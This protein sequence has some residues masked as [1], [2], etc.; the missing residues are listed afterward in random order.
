MKARYIL[1]VLISLAIFFIW[2]CEKDLQIFEEA[3]NDIQMN[4]RNNESAILSNSVLPW[5]H[6]IVSAPDKQGT[7][8]LIA[9]GVDG[10]AHMVYW[11][12]TKSEKINGRWYVTG[13]DLF[14]RNTSGGTLSSPV[15]ITQL[16]TSSWGGPGI[17]VDQ[18]GQVHI[19]YQVKT[20]TECG[21][22]YTKGL[23]DDLESGNF[24]IEGPFWNSAIMGDCLWPGNSWGDIDQA[25]RLHLI[26]VIDQEFYYITNSHG[27]FE[28]FEI[29]KSDFTNF[30]TI[31]IEEQDGI[32]HFAFSASKNSDHNYD[33]YYEKL[34]PDGSFSD[35]EFVTNMGG[36]DTFP[37]IEIDQDQSVHIGHYTYNPEGTYYSNNKSGSFV[38][39]LV[40]GAGFFGSDF[41]IQP[42]KSIGVAL[43]DISSRI[44]IYVNNSNITWDQEVVYFPEDNESISLAG[45]IANNSDGFVHIVTDHSRTVGKYPRQ[46]IRN[47]VVYHTNDPN[48]QARGD[49]MHVEAIDMELKQKGPNW[50]AIADVLI[51]DADLSPLSEA[52]VTGEWSELVS[53]SVTATT[54]EDGYVR[55]NSP[56]TRDSGRI[57]FTV[58]GV[59]KVGYTYDEETNTETS[60]SI[61]N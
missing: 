31:D 57:T 18:S 47:E 8:L 44:I 34:N 2:S 43:R 6:A 19:T 58:R 53:G 27:S 55:F 59:S 37:W 33:I 12:E 24:S 7:S 1:T 10:E 40:R 22:F 35:P 51:F 32:V 17:H 16:Q 60:D 52:N 3:N 13:Y 56:K 30:G 21:L 45:A 23:P 49:L 41:V 26:S 39:E 20:D 46:S 11:Q 9:T 50:N 48:F 28:F 15:Q 42:D 54:G 29:N 4:L 61:N 38:T 14:Y 36:E 25:G 5:K